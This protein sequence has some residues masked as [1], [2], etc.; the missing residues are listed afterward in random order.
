MRAL[1]KA[2]RAEWK[3]WRMVGFVEALADVTMEAGSLLL[4]LIFW[5]VVGSLVYSAV[6]FA[7]GLL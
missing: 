3:Y 7:W 1:L 6:R 4:C 5:G 2:F